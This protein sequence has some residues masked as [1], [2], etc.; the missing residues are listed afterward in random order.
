MKTYLLPVLCI[1][2]FV[3]CSNEESSETNDTIST[4]ELIDS[5]YCNCEELTLDQP[6]N[7]FWR[8]ERRVGFT[9]TCEEFYPDGT[10]KITK[11]LVDGKLHGKQFT[12]YE[13]G[14]PHTEKEFDMNF[15]TGESITFTNTGEVKFHALYKRGKQTEVLVNKPHLLEEDPW[16]NAN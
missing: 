13:N 11:N 6:Y 16:K 3:S 8:F 12:Y 4:G 5:A 7:H 9:G 14:R 2:F 1:L 10:L 15:Q